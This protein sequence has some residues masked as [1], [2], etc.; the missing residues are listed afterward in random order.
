[1]PAKDGRRN[2]KTNQKWTLM[3]YID[4]ISMNA[5][6]KHLASKYEKTTYAFSGQSTECKIRIDFRRNSNANLIGDFF[7]L[8]DEIPDESQDLMVVDP[9]F[10]LYNPGL[11]L[12]K[13]LIKRGLM[14]K[15]SEKTRFFGHPHLW[16]KV[17]FQKVKQGGLFVSK[18]NIA[19]TQVLS[20]WPQL[21]YVHDTRPM[22][23]IVRLD[24]K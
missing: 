1:M 20:K 23:H 18:R 21:W 12:W 24:R 17:A 4:N 8:L 2:C 9:L 3:T 7:E 6:I 15:S 14:P 13:K 11:P 10:D 5:Y 19:S 16:Q 22:A